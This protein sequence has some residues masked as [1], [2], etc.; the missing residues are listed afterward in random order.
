[1]KKIVLIITLIVGFVGFGQQDTPF[2][3]EGISDPDKL[4]IAKANLKEGD[5]FFNSAGR[6]DIAQSIVYYLKANEINPNNAELNFKIGVAYLQGDHKF[7]ALDYFIKAKSLNSTS[8]LLMDIDFYLGKGYHLKMDW[9]NA[10]KYYK[11]YLEK[12]KGS[13]EG[14]E[15][16]E[17]GLN[18]IKI[19]RK[20]AENPLRVWIDNVGEKINSPYPEH[21]PL[22]SADGRK[23]FLTSRRPDS[24]GGLMDENEMYFEDVYYVE[25]VDGE[26]TEI[27]NIGDSVNTN[28]HDATV[29][30]TADGFGLLVFRGINKKS[31]GIY[32]SRQDDNGIWSTP[33]RFVPDEPKIKNHTPSGTF[34]FDEKRAYFV[35]DLPGSLGKHDIFYTEWNEEEKKWGEN[36]RLPD[37]INTEL[38]ERGVFLMPDDKTLYFSSEGHGSMGGLDIFKTVLQDDGSW[39]DPVNVG[40]PINT[41]DDDLYFVLTGNGRYGYYST[42]RE[43]G[44]GDKDIYKITFLGDPKEPAISAIQPSLDLVFA[45][46]IY[47]DI[48]EPDNPILTG[49]ITDGLDGLPCDAEVEIINI[50]K[51]QVVNKF[52]SNGENGEYSVTVEPA[53]EYTISV[54]KYGY[55]FKSEN[56]KI[57]PGEGYRKYIKDIEIFAVEDLLAVNENPNG[58]SSTGDGTDSTKKTPPASFKLNNILFKF[59]SYQ[60]TSIARRDLDKLATLMKENKGVKIQINGYTDSRGVKSYNVRLSKNRAKAVRDYLI[61]KGIDKSRLSFKGFGATNPIVTDAEIAK[62]TSAADRRAAHLKNRRTEFEI[63]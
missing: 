34:T 43:G 15:Q 38:D 23:M 50:T 40:Y 48:F 4:A 24:K 8:K 53:T 20:L 45:D 3:K 13:K 14:K 63:K 6:I 60:L 7:E 1:M 9:D 56:F 39:S 61:A 29:G 5:R 11:Q 19:G 52:R 37:N 32:L 59:D 31:G 46:D 12:D 44:F 21:S 25:K 26:W 35:S 17:R 30:L 22:V 2:T 36:I 62:M 28:Y 49:K 27:K 41:P 47:A 16:A 57:A 33:K 18:E 10:E 54:S 51:D 58:N 55:T 42:Y